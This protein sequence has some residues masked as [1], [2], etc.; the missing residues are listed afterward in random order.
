MNSLSQTGKEVHLIIPAS[1]EHLDTTRLALYGV[2]VRAAF[3]YEAIEDLKVAVTE[4]CTHAILQQQAR[5]GD[6]ALHLRFILLEDALE[7]RLSSVGHATRF[8]GAVAEAGPLAADELA[9]VK[10]E[11]LGLY[12]MQALVDEVR[13]DEEGA[14]RSEA[15]VLVKR[16]A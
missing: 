3:S 2:A 10:S 1:P 12:L 7:V 16:R 8:A 14:D 9:E 15:V 11:L 5:G 13:I 6:G 4:A